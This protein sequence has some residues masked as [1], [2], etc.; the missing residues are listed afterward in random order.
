MHFA[1]KPIFTVLTY[2]LNKVLRTGKLPDEYKL[3]TICPVPK[4]SKSAR[5]PTNYR[6]TTI[7]SIV[8]KV[9][10]VHIVNL[11]RKTADPIQSPLQFGFTS[12]ILPNFATLIVTEVMNQANSNKSPLYMYHALMDTS[13]AF[14]VVDHRGMLNSTY[15]QGIH[16]QLWR[17]LDSM[18]TNY[19]SMVNHEGES[20]NP[21]PELQNIHQ[22]GSS[23][24]DIYKLGKN[25]L[26]NQLNCMTDNR[27]GHFKVGALMVTDDLLLNSSNTS[28]L[29]I[30]IALAEKDASQEWYKFNADKTKIVAVRTLQDTPFMLYNKELGYSKDEPHLGIS[31]NQQNNKDTIGKRIQKARRTTYSLLG[32]GLSGLK[33]V[34]PE[35]AIRGFNIYILPIL[36][37]GLEALVQ[38]KAE[39]NDLALFQREMLQRFMK[40]PDST[41]IPAIHLLSGILPVK[42]EIH[43]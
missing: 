20:S 36:L 13:K 26:P 17:T 1:A 15:K 7:T 42:A 18:Y 39:V 40:L 21:F 12:G 41:A 6:R 33:N 43:K 24:A 23:S 30:A 19:H 2:L 14:D 25:K 35:V 8:S 4:K 37:H 28:E 9:A 22:G 27:I 38:T 29:Q 31:R 11:M 16:G 3:G 5:L 10:E 34:G 32:A